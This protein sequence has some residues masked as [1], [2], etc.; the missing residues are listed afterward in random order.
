MSHKRT[1]RTVVVIRSK[2]GTRLARGYT[3]PEL[4]PFAELSISNREPAQGTLCHLS[5]GNSE[6]N[7]DCESTRGSEENT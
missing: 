7:A 5:S 1:A 2:R 4:H 3:V 6:V